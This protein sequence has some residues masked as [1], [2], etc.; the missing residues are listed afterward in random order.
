[1]HQA[2][3]ALLD[4]VCLAPS[5]RGWAAALAGYEALLLRELGYGDTDLRPHS[6]DFPAILAAL[7][8]LGPLLA[9]YVLADRHSGVKGTDIMAARAILRDRLGKIAS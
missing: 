8:R 6:D 7:D 3:A 4:A 5:A 2:L 9:R 1:L